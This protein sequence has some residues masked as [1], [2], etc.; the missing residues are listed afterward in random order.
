MYRSW[1]LEDSDLLTIIDGCQQKYE[2]GIISPELTIMGFD[3]FLAALIIKSNKVLLI[4]KWSVDD[5]VKI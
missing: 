5:D 2:N 4:H 3:L 1:K